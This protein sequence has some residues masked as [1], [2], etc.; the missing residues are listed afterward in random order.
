MYV[1]GNSKGDVLLICLYVDD[2]LVTGNN[3]KDIDEFKKKMMAE[4]QM[5][6]LGILTYF[7]GMEFKATSKGIILHQK[8]YLQE[9]LERFQMSNYNA[10]ITPAD[11]G[12]KLSRDQDEKAVDHTLY[13][14]IVG[15]LRY[16]CN[17]RPDIAYSVGLISRFMDDPKSSHLVAAKRIL[18]YLKGT[19]DYGLLFPATSGKSREKLMGYADADWCGDLVERKSTTGYVF[20]FLNAAVSWCSKKQNVVALSSCEAEYIAAS[21]AACQVAWL[22]SLIEELQV[23]LEGPVQLLVDNKSAINLAKNPVAHGRSKHIETRFHFLRDQVNKEKIELVYCKTDEQAAD[24]L[25]KPLKGDKFN[26]LREMLG[27][28]SLGI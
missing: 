19:S 26:Q 2:L 10:A 16:I 8:K 20:K 25:T 1:K 12:I 4:F 11:C 28:V 5:T 15:C 27:V 14:Q 7:L 23:K 17:S 9:V 21:Y 13:K 22:Q 6:D 18:R 24:I 3:S